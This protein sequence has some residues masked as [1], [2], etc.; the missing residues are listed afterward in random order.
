MLDLSQKKYYLG[1]QKK[2][3]LTFTEH[4]CDI[5]SEKLLNLPHSLATLYRSMQLIFFPTIFNE[6]RKMQ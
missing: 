4:V 2:I 1:Y 3:E 5:I 6:K